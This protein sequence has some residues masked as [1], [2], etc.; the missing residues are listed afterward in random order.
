M[1]GKIRLNMAEYAGVPSQS[2]RVA[3]ELSNG[4]TLIATITSTFLGMGK[5]KG[6]GSV[7][8]SEASG[9][10][11]FSGGGG[12]GG[13]G[14]GSVGGGGAGAGSDQD[15]LTD[16]EID[17]DGGSFRS[18]SDV[19]RTEADV[20]APAPPARPPSGG[21]AAPSSGGYAAA[22][23]APNRSSRS[24]SPSGSRDYAPPSAANPTPPR[25]EAPDRSGSTRAGLGSLRRRKNAP[26]PGP[27][28]RPTPTSWPS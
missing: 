1:V 14:G 23:A 17:D 22:G 6:G 28:R 20:T 11:S 3:A 21:Y 16:L 24:A 2:R 27:P 10:T 26:P 4:S 15:D 19:G 8:G 13:G 12:G 18:L 25:D 5:S 9:I 7:A